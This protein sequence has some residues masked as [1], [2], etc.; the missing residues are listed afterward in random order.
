MAFRFRNL[1]QIF[2]GRKA[3]RQK[4]TANAGTARHP[5]FVESATQFHAPHLASGILH[6]QL[7]VDVRVFVNQQDLIHQQGGN[8]KKNDC[9]FHCFP[10]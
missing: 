10:S 3:L 4:T 2:Y 8:R 7:L 6:E 9:C 1:R 5:I